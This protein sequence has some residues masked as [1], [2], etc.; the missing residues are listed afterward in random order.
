[1]YVAF[2]WR[3]LPGGVIKPATNPM[4]R[5][6]AGLAGLDGGARRPP[7]PGPQPED[8]KGRTELNELLS[9]WDTAVRTRI[10]NDPGLK[11]L[12]DKHRFVLLHARRLNRL[13][14]IRDYH[15][16]AY[17]FV[18]STSDVAWHRNDVQLQFGNGNGAAFSVNLLG[19]QENLIVDLGPVDFS[20]D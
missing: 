19:G 17:S 15:H 11:E 9:Q 20:K 3:L 7:G 10:A 12:T 2:L 1:R 13:Y 4:G 8:E 16:C 14:G 18:E 5:A 6:G